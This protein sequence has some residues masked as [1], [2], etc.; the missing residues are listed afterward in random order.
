MIADACYIGC[1]Q[2]YDLETNQWVNTGMPQPTLYIATEQDINEIQIMM[3]AFLAAVDSDRISTGEYYEGEWE[4][5]MRAAEILRQGKIYFE[6]LPDFSLQDIENV[7][8][9]GIRDHEVT[10]IF[11]DYIHTSMKILE[12]ITRRSGGVK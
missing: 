1:G 2:M 8:K 6:S 12:E 11:H 4:R 10:Y 9:K 3:I 7:I 5:V